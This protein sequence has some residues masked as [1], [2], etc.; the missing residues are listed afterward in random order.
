MLIGFA[1]YTG[2]EFISDWNN[3]EVTER[4]GQIQN[5]E[6]TPHSFPEPP[7]EANPH[8]LRRVHGCYTYDTKINLT[9]ED[10][11]THFLSVST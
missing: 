4:A 6:R 5:G 9:Q 3:L 10:I 2:L 8:A 1:E 11:I 7:R